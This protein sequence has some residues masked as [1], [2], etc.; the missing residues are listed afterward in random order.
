[1]AR[2]SAVAAA[3]LLVGCAAVACAQRVTFEAGS[4]LVRT[5]RGRNSL[6]HATHTAVG[7]VQVA[8]L[9]RSC[10]KPGMR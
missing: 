4:Y 7:F 9:L 8:T 10:C 2:H 1:M 3:L 6:P 5:P